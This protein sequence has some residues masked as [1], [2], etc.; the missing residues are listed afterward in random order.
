M[1]AFNDTSAY[2]LSRSDPSVPDKQLRFCGN[3]DEAKAHVRVLLE[4]IGATSRYVPHF[5]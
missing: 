4:S 3:Y 2:E 1:K 5:T